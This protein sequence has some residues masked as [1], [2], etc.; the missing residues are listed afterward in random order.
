MSTM[1]H[2]SLFELSLELSLLIPLN[3]FY[4]LPVC[5]SFQLSLLLSLGHPL[6]YGHLYLPFHIFSTPFLA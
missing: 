5:V 3:A 6:A 2:R 4:T 1:T